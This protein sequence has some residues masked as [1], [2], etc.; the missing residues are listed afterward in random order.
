MFR[1]GYLILLFTTLGAIACQSTV[2]TDGSKDYETIQVDPKSRPKQLAA[3]MQTH[4]TSLRPAKW[5]KLK[6]SLESPRRLEF[7]IRR[8]DDAQ[9]NGAND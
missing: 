8:R 9:S 3:S 7:R 4:L 5:K 1:F 2:I 6:K